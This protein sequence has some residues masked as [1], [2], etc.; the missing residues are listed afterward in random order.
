MSKI[1]CSW[2]KRIHETNTDFRLLSY[3]FA[4]ANI[5]PHALLWKTFPFKKNY[6]ERVDTVKHKVILLALNYYFFVNCLLVECDGL[7][8]AK[9]VYSAVPIYEFNIFES[10]EKYCY[11][12]KI[13]TN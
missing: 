7:S 2:P 10:F 5:F 1:D 8:F 13:L 11:L 3:L 6:D 9:R 4:E 12:F